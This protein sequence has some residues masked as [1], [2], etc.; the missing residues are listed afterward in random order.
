MTIR[1]RLL[2]LTIGLV[3]P[4]VLVGFYNLW[5]AWQAS[6]AELDQSIERQAEL[7]A[8][9]FEQWIEA[10]TQTLTTISNLAAA[11]NQASLRDYLN[12]IV[13][14]RP[15][16]L[17]VQIVNPA[18]EVI[19]SQTIRARPLPLVSIE[20]LRQEVAR[21]NKLVVFTEQ[22]SDENLRLL[23]LALPIANGNFVVA[24]IDGTSASEIFRRLELPEE[25][26]IAVL[27]PNNRLLYRNRVSPEQMSVDVSNTPL[28]VSLGEGQ[29]ATI[30]IESPFDKIRRVYGL[31]RVETANCVVMVGVP[32]ERLY[33][34][35]Q[36]QYWRQLWFGLVIVSFAILF[37]LL[38]S[39]GIVNPLRH[40]TAAARSFG[41]GDLE[42]R[43][44]VESGGTIRELGETFNQMA[45]QIKER[46]EKL[47]ELDRLKSEFVSSVSHELRTPLTTIKTL[48][49]VLR[50]NNISQTER[51]EYLRTIAVECD[52]QIEFVQNLLDLSRIE[53]GAYK[54]SPT[55]TEIGELLR[56]VIAGQEKTAV[57]RNL[58]LRI[59]P[60]ISEKL[61]ALTDPNILKRVVSSLIENAMKY[62]PENGFIEISACKGSSEEIAITITDNG[63]GIAAEDL[64][65]IFERFYRGR[66]LEKAANS[67]ENLSSDECQNG[68]ETFGIGL[69][70]YLVKNLTAQIGGRITAESPVENQTGTRFTVFIP[71]YDAISN[72]PERAEQEI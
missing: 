56:K 66:P 38:V 31:A 16:W 65:H 55:K 49:H 68:A 44:R 26:I 53:S 40:L 67:D 3:V 45:E 22:I 24:R 35:A 47:Q 27:D 42:T 37:A 69:G 23:S 18:G 61:F 50:R 63:C 20:T 11:E 72:S 8:T 71:V 62:T 41:A 19:L 29:T 4:L 17:D 58:D 64:P 14:T 59:K 57:T 5:S 52:R 48:A 7:A 32:S 15:H 6:R 13:K 70:L 1:A 25:N 54:V 60:P 33:A 10:Q 36:R 51:D 2:W 39:H 46:E 9:A 21:E 34:Q 12:S 30:E 28:L 43:A